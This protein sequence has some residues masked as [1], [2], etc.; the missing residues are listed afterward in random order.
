MDVD[1]AKVQIWIELVKFFVKFL[2]YSV[3]HIDERIKAF[4]KQ[5]KPILLATQDKLV[6]VVVGY[7]DDVRVQ[8]P[9]FV[10]IVGEAH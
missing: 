2:I 10:F 7:V 5:D 1:V 8:K 6:V 9:V 3:A 4:C